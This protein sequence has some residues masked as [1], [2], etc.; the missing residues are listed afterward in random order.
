MQAVAKTAANFALVN[1]MSTPL[2]F[3]PVLSTGSWC[4]TA[5]V[6]RRPD[7]SEARGDRLRHDP[8]PFATD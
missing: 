7:S 2:F 5:G 1:P 6:V 4:E 3:R 8:E